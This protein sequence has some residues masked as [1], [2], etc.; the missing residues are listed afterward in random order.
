MR[1][2]QRTSLSEVIQDRIVYRNLEPYDPLLPGLSELRSQLALPERVIPRKNE[3]D[4]ARVVYLLLQACQRMDDSSI[5]LDTLIFLGDTQLLD[6]TAYANLRQVSGWEGMAFIGSEDS[7]PAFLKPARVADNYQIFLS[8]RWSA[9]EEF[10]HC[11]ADRG[12]R[13]GAGTAV[14]IDMDKTMV[15]ARGRNAKVIDQTRVRA[16]EKTVSELLGE[17]FNPAIFRS[18]YEPLNQPEF[19]AFTADNQDY[20]AYVC[21]MLSAGAFSFDDLVCRIRSGEMLTFSQFIAEVDEK[22]SNFE[23]GLAEIHRDIF[24]NVCSGDPTPFKSFRRNEYLLT[25]ERFGCS[26]DSDPVGEILAEEIVITQEVREI[27]LRWRERGALLFGLSDKPDEASIPTQ[28]LA[29]RGYK[30]LH[31][32]VTHSIGM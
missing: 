21:L 14:V 1:I 13:I 28:E 11:C 3:L 26:Q 9:L 29:L 25:V 16:V 10:D 8:N 2:F 27:A 17:S 23:L 5:D 32:A 19:H 20:L 24:A 4:Y 18:Y 7:Q 30:P 12:I 15:G 31:R 6:A 22:S